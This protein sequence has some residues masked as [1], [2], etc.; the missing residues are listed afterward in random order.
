M[1]TQSLFVNELKN[2]ILY[3]YFFIS[4]SEGKPE[5]MKSQ[6]QN[7]SNIFAIRAAL[8]SS[9][10]F[11]TWGT[12]AEVGQIPETRECESP[13]KSSSL[14]VSRRKF[15][16]DSGDLREEGTRGTFREFILFHFI[17]I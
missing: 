11:L 5:A 12:G 17:I 15:S 4:S 7:K 9:E 8:G 6:S 14:A 2:L 16:P 3:Y 13:Q 10:V 1:D